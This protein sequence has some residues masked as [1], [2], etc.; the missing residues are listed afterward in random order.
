MTKWTVPLALLFTSLVACG[1]GDGDGLDDWQAQSQ[2][3]D[4]IAC[5]SA[6]TI[7]ENGSVTVRANVCLSSSCSRNAVSSCEVSLDGDTLTVTSQFDWEENVGEGI[8]CTDDCQDIVAQ[9]GDVG[10]LAEGSY[11]L[12]HGDASETVEVPNEEACDGSW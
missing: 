11:T 1:E 2:T 10:P 3:N 12:A 7:D 8:A 6:P 4:G 5:L 9:C